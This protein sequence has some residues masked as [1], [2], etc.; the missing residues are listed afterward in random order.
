MTCRAWVFMIF[1]LPHTTSSSSEEENFLYRSD[2]FSMSVF[3]LRSFEKPQIRVWYE[4]CFFCQVSLNLPPHCPLMTF[5]FV[6]MLFFSISPNLYANYD[7]FV[8]SVF[9]LQPV[10]T[11]RLRNQKN[12]FNSMRKMGFFLLV[13]CKSKSHNII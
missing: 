2:I 12:I 4:F 9:L 1:P 10:K 5:W 3:S 7:S 11:G 8:F 13:K 6:T